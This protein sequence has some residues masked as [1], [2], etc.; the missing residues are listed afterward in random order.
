MIQ[1]SN[2]DTIIKFGIGTAIVTIISLSFILFLNKSKKKNKGLQLCP[3]K[4]LKKI[5]HLR[6]R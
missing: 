4:I 1:N 6:L 2:G 5:T 3:F